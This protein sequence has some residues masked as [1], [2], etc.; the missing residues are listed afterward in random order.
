MITVSTALYRRSMMKEP[1]KKVRGFWF[2]SIGSTAGYND[3]TKAW[4]PDNH[5][6]TYS[7]AVREAKAEAK[8][9][10]ATIIYVLP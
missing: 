10:G 4:S 9:R 8:K 1:P 3:I 7:E 5:Y 6:L 2:F